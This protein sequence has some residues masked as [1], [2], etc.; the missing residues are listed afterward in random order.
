MRNILDSGWIR[1]ALLGGVFAMTW[2]LT[3][4]GMRFADAAL[5]KP[6]TD[7]LGIAA[8]IG[9]VGTMPIA[10]LGLVFTKYMEFR[11]LK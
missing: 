11:S 3:D 2:R 7:W 8:T 4:W 10:L 6:V 9:A 1:V 5:V